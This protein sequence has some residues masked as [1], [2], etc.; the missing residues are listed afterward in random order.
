MLYRQGG[1][2]TGQSS[3]G[4]D[5]YYSQN[6]NQVRGVLNFFLAQVCYFC[7]IYHKFRSFETFSHLRNFTNKVFG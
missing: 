6:S 4:N 5:Q 1:Y 2:G 3:Y 7:K